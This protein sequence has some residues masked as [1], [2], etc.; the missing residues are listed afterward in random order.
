MG[1]GLCAVSDAN[2]ISVFNWGPENKGA[3]FWRAAFVSAM[4]SQLPKKKQ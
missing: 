4:Q 3:C 1:Q 2:H